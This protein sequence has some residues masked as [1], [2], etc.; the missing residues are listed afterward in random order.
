M[1]ELLHTEFVSAVEL[2]VFR[3]ELARTSA[4]AVL[5]LFETDCRSGLYQMRPI[6]FDRVASEARAICRRHCARLGTRTLDLLHVAFAVN[7][8]MQRFATADDRQAS[9][10]SAVGLTVIRP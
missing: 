5:A 1:T 9:A 10:A 4:D 6:D 7:L 2:K 8:G 3:G